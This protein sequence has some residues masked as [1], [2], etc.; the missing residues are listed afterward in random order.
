MSPAC[1]A[2]SKLT[3]LPRPLLSQKYNTTAPKAR[4]KTSST[5]NATVI[6]LRFIFLFLSFI[7]NGLMCANRAAVA[8]AD[9][10]P[11]I[12]LMHIQL[13]YFCT[14]AA[15]CAAVRVYLYAEYGIFV[16]QR[17]NCPQWAKKPAKWPVNKYACQQDNP[18]PY[19]PPP[20]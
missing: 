1:T 10:F 17:I 11:V 12:D 4:H 13:T 15:A 8:A 9:T 20:K 14:G 18:K 6:V 5:N 3:L 2:F 19:Q 7:N 16:E